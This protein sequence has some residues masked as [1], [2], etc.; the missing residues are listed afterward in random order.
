M[1]AV[2]VLADGSTKTILLEK[3]CLA[4]TVCQVP[5]VYK[6]A[7]SEYIEVY[8]TDGSHEQINKY[9]LSRETTD[10]IIQRTGEIISV[11][12]YV[13]EKNLVA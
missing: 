10:K 3:D 6:K 1:N 11:K 4:F 5:V 12:V 2:F 9:E 13:N 8:C 7:P